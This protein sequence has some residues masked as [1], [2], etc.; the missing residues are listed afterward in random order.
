M[1]LALN[2]PGGNGADTIGELR[3][4]SPGGAVLIVSASLHPTNTGKVM[5]AGDVVLW[6]SS[7]ARE[8]VGTVRRLGSRQRASGRRHFAGCTRHRLPR[9]PSN[10]QAAPPCGRAAV[11]RESG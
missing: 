1:G 7:R 8:A 2:P 4:A 10:R 9:M 3:D 6:V 11:R 5:R